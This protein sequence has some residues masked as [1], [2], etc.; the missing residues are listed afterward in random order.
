MIPLV[1]LFLLLT[2]ESL[3]NDITDALKNKPEWKDVLEFINKTEAKLRS[4]ARKNSGSKVVFQV[5]HSGIPTIV[6]APNIIKFDTILVNKRLGYKADTG[7]FTCRK[8]GLYFFG[9][10]SLATRGT[11]TDVM[12]MK[13]GS[14]KRGIHTDM[15]GKNAQ[16]AMNN[17]ILYL[18][19]GDE[20][21]VQV[22]K[23]SIWCPGRSITFQGFHVPE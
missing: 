21:W 14:P 19:K 20:M 7:T 22:T 23:G 8:S 9:F 4:L 3:G 16:V 17:I 12:L 13:D 10:S 1:S 15:K 18:N 5:E 2:S 11:K 6:H